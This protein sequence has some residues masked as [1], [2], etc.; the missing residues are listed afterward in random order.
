MNYGENLEKKGTVDVVQRLGPEYEPS[1]NGTDPRLDPTPSNSLG[2]ASLSA[3]NNAQDAPPDIPMR[4]SLGF[5]FRQ[6]S[7]SRPD[8][9]GSDRQ[10]TVG[11][12][13]IL[14][15]NHLRRV[16]SRA[17]KSR[18]TPILRDLDGLI[19]AGEMLLVL[20]PPGRYGDFYCQTSVIGDRS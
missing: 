14:A 8:R 10:P 4:K 5:A 7:I 11:N 19:H 6:L 13:P 16:L 18:T 15:F 9:D 2:D 12:V 17:R 20:G 3:L 1:S